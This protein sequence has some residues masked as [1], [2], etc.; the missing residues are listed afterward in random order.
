MIKE[1]TI[2]YKK[3]REKKNESMIARALQKIST[4]DGCIEHCSRKR[5]CV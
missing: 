3:M 2:Y 5:N 1:M 4:N